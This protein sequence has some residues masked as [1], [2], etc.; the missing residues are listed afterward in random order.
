MKVAIYSRGGENVQP[1]DLQNLTDKL[2]RVKISPV[3]HEDIFS[4]V[5]H[6]LND[7]SSVSTFK[8]STDLG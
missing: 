6:A 3:I 7:V 5:S 2:A 1:A 4:Q 8:D